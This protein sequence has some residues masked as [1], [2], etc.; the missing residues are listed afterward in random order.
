MPT[1]DISLLPNPNNGLVQLVGIAG[2]QTPPGTDLTENQSTRIIAT[3]VVLILFSTIAVVLRL[4][5]R[6][7]SKAGF[8]WDDWTI[9]G[10]LV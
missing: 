7:L 3:S 4:I 2:I 9:L 8:W 1:P 10:A 5:A 6:R